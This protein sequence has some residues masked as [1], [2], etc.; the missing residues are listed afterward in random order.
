M[1]IDME[2]NYNLKRQLAD[3]EKECYEVLLFV[4][5]QGLKDYSCNLS[6]KDCPI[7]SL[8]FEFCDYAISLLAVLSTLFMKNLLDL[9]D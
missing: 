7:I 6:L 4:V 9:N 1:G 5:N 2:W 8:H 3:Q